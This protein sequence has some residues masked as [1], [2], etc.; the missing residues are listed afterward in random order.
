MYRQVVVLSTSDRII[1]CHVKSCDDPRIHLLGSMIE[2]MAKLNRTFDRSLRDSVGIGQSWFE[3]LLRLERS[4]GHL[5]MGVL[6]EQ[7]SLT[8]GGVTRLVDK[9]TEAGLVSRR[10]CPE[11]RRV[12]YVEVTDAG[13]AVLD[14][15][16]EVHLA[17]IDRE[18]MERVSADERKVIVE[19]MD[20]L[21]STVPAAG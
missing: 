18:V 5:P 11:D 15:A 16:I 14:E 9:M 17:D 8:S 21:R 2:A 13:R 4:G 7:I 6:A 10:A 12:L 19:V 20:R 3:A 1:S